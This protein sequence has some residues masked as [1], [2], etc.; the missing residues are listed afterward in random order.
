MTAL[1]DTWFDGRMCNVEGS[2]GNDERLC[3]LNPT[4]VCD[5]VATCQHGNISIGSKDDDSVA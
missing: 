2:E 3:M 5:G 1:S 4:D